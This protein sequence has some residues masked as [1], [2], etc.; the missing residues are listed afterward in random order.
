MQPETITESQME[1]VILVAAALVEILNI[2]YTAFTNTIKIRVI[3]EKLSKYMQYL[4]P[5]LLIFFLEYN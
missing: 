2:K 3:L 4:L 1:G 5:Y